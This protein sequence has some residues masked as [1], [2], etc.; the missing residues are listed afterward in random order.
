MSGSTVGA[1]WQALTKL[2]GDIQDHVHLLDQQI[3]KLNGIVDN[4]KGSWK[5][6]GANAY[7]TLQQQVN[8]DA[9]NLRK[10][11][12]AIRQAVE[13]AKTGFHSADDEQSSKFRSVDGSII[14]RLS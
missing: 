9:R 11:L 2:Q 3:S 8:D 5:G 12:E 13:D 14:D 7:T 1:E 4:V 6:Q 10:V